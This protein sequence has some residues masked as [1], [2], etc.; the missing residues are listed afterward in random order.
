MLNKYIDSLSIDDLINLN[1]GMYIKLPNN[2]IEASKL[3][4]YSKKK[5]SLI[6]ETNSIETYLKN[7]FKNY[8]DN[9]FNNLDINLIWDIMIDIFK[10]NIII[11]EVQY[12][13]DINKSSVKCPNI[14]RKTGLFDKNINKYCLLFKI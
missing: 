5:K 2:L 1:D 14:N 11:I 9:N 4:D 8:F 7:E 12:E 3:V 13:N 10:I 6:S